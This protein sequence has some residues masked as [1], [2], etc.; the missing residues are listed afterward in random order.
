MQITFA[1]SVP[2]AKSP[3]VAGF[4][5]HRV[6]APV[7][8]PQTMG[9]S[10]SIDLTAAGFTASKVLEGVQIGL[11]GVGGPAVL[12]AGIAIGIGWMFKVAK[13]GKSVAR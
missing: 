5:A 11:N 3:V 9:A 13:K 1:P 8:R 7:A 2:E 6:G 12:L 10:P 4:S